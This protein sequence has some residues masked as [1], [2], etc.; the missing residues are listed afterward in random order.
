M[1]TNLDAFTSLRKS[2]TT[3]VKMGDGVIRETQGRGIVKVKSSEMSCIKNVFNLNISL[4]KIGK[5]LLEG[6][7]FAYKDLVCF[8]FK[9]KTKRHSLVKVPMAK[10]FLLS[11]GGHT[12]ACRFSLS[13]DI[14]LWLDT[15]LLSVGQFLLEGY[16]LV[17]ED[18]VHSFFKIKSKG[19]LLVKVPRAKNIFFFL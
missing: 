8:V 5:F 14:W 10:I 2:M 6:Y 17:F 16:L 3:Q 13:Y 15:S 1:T 19:N 11:L 12:H 4:L 7:T 18:L 9:N